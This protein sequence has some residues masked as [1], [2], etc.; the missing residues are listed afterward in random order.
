MFSNPCPQ[1]GRSKGRCT[2]FLVLKFLVLDPQTV[3]CL[4]EQQTLMPKPCACY[5]IYSGLQRFHKLSK[6]KSVETENYHE[7]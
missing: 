7:L 3:L 4:T 5:L 6:Q 2:G 1:N